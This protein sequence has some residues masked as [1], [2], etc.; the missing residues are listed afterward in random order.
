MSCCSKCMSLANCRLLTLPLGGVATPAD[1]ALMMH[2]GADGVFVGSGIFKSDNPEKF[3]RA[4][5]EATTHYTDYKLI[6][7]V[8]KNLGAP[9]K[10][11]DIATLT[12]AERMSER[13][14]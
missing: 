12:P 13:G 14:C 10:G 4:I 1:A 6:A 9:M 2:L 11:I 8:S 3:A 7:E 5:V